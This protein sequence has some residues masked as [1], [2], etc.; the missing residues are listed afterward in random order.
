[1]QKVILLVSILF[2]LISCNLSGILQDANKGKI[3]SKA[4]NNSV[5]FIIYPTTCTVFAISKTEF[6]TAA[7]CVN[8]MRSS[9]E[10][11]EILMKRKKV[12]VF[13]SK[14]NNSS[15]LA[16]LKIADKNK[17]VPIKLAT[18]EEL[19]VGAQVFTIGA[20]FGSPY[21]FSSGYVSKIYKVKMRIDINFYPGNSGGPI[22]N[23][24]GRLLGVVS[25]TRATMFETQR[26]GI[27]PHC[28]DIE[29]FLN[30]R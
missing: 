21:A 20:P 11:L 6:L 26:I 19:F 9:E 5:G 15:D 12:K 10:L 18:K 13:V 29:K 25:A 22:I 17:V 30:K 4:V 1:M 3:Y 28:L 27:A 24:Y 2:L 16:L 7:H 23:N 8:R 14:F